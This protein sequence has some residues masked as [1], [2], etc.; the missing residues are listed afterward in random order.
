MEQSDY[1]SLLNRAVLKLDSNTPEARAEIYERARRALRNQLGAMQPRLPDAAIAKEL[2]LLE[3]AIR[4]LEPP[5]KIQ[6]EPPGKPQAPAQQSRSVASRGIFCESCVAETTDETPGDVSTLNGIG[7]QFYGSAAPCPECASVIRTLWWTLVSLPVVPLASY[8]YKTSEEH[9][10]RARFWCR[11]LP[12]RHWNQ[13]FKTW[14]I[15]L[16]AGTAV[17]IGIY[18]YDQYK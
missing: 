12:A 3:G 17:F 15:G 11:K 16:V 18:V 9:G 7:R 10:T 1:F 14:V 8:R 6:P 13:I 5:P 4:Q 2:Q